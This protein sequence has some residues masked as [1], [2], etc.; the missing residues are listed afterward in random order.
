M[1]SRA[2][3]RRGGGRRGRRIRRRDRANRRSGSRTCPSPTRASWSRRPRARSCHP[4]RRRRRPHAS[5][6]PRPPGPRRG[7]LPARRSRP[8]RRPASR[9]SP[10]RA[11]GRR[12]R[13]PSRSWSPRSCP[14]PGPR[15][16]RRPRDP[17]APSCRS[18]A[19]SSRT[20]NVKWLAGVRPRSIGD[21]LRDRVEA[22]RPGQDGGAVEDRHV[23]AGDRI[24]RGA[25][26]P[27]RE[28]DRDAC[29]RSGLSR[30]RS[31]R[32]GRYAPGPAAEPS[33]RPASMTR[34][35]ERRPPRDRGC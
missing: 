12:A 20:G 1:S 21:D 34:G 29:H 16:R 8:R 27:A 14:C 7:G 26:G 30:G 31:G 23:A 3:A 22:G 17:P 13:D 28:H 25:D 18:P 4:G 19:M 9:R 35:Q 24:E 10:R 5:T 6:P 2:V 11:S 32:P 15:P 33:G